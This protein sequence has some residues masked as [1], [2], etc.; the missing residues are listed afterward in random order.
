MSTP[1]ARTRRAQEMFTRIEN[2]LA[3]KGQ[4]GGLTQKAFCEQQGLALTTFQNWLQKYRARQ[5]QRENPPASRSGFIPLHV[6]QA[7]IAAPPLSCVIEF[8]NGVII[9]LSGQVDMQRL[10]HLVTAR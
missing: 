10:S 6:R 4:A 2:Y 7:P 5:R 8:P 3:A 1:V 9:R